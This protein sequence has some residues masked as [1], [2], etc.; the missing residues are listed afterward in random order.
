MS[1]EL[2]L[3]VR[4]ALGRDQRQF[5]IES[6]HS[7]LDGEFEDRYV[8][9]SGY[10]GPYKPELFAAA[11]DL[12]EALKAMVDKFDSEIHN[13]Y[14]GTGMLEDRLSEANFARRIIAKAEG[15]AE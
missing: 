6:N 7:E 3:T 4:T 13:E 14:D 12:L 2:K 1:E 9:F 11:P 15:R 10:F 8:L 5:A